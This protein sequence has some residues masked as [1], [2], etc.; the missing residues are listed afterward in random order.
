MISST[1]LVGQ[2]F[3]CS[4]SRNADT[5]SGMAAAIRATRARTDRIVL[6]VG[7]GSGDDPVER[8]RI[9]ERVDV[10]GG[11][12]RLLDRARFA[13]SWRGRSWPLLSR[14]CDDRVDIGGRRRD[15]SIAAPHGLA[16]IERHAKSEG[17]ESLEHEAENPESNSVR[18]DLTASAA[19][20]NP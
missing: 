9:D 18:L 10:L 4:R 6:R 5:W 11:R 16:V 13:R 2:T 20:R 19:T 17:G 7:V 1:S 14:A 3:S 15:R 12:A 8:E